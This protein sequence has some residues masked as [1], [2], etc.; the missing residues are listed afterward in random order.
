[1]TEPNEAKGGASFEEALTRNVQTLR[2]RLV[3]GALVALVV[4]AALAVGLL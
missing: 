3:A 2:A 4:L 1:M